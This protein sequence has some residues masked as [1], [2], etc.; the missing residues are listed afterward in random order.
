MQKNTSSD[1]L[2]NQI[3][4]LV[5]RFVAASRV[6]AAEAMEPAF[7]AASGEVV[8]KQPRPRKP[9]KHFGVPRRSTFGSPDVFVGW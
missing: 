9:V 4:L 2:A 3:E 1:E 6:A 7:A 5:G 8:P